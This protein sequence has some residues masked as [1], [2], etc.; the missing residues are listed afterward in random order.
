M[1]NFPYFDK[2][3]KNIRGMMFIDTPGHSDFV[4]NRTM[5]W[6]LADIAILVI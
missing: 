5:G 3:N 4:K 2:I 1:K 6:S